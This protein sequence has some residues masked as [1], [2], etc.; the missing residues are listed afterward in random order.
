MTSRTGLIASREIDIGYF[1][2]TFIKRNNRTQN[3]HE[4]VNHQYL[5]R[6]HDEACQKL[7][8]ENYKYFVFVFYLHLYG[9]LEGKRESSHATIIILILNVKLL[10]YSI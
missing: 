5:L 3:N 2:V 10:S 9:N 4:Y 8:K 1:T 6:N 7:I